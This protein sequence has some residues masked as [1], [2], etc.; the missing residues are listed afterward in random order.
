MSKQAALTRMIERSPMPLSFGDDKVLMAINLF[1]MMAMMYIGGAVVV[2]KVGA[3]IRHRAYDKIWPPHPV[4]LHRIMWACA[5][6]ALTLRCV[7]ETSTLLSWSPDD[8]GLGAVMQ[9][10]KRYIDPISIGFAIT[11]VVVLTLV[12]DSLEQQLRRQPLP[13]NM[14]AKKREL[15]RPSLVVLVSLAMA[16]GVVFTRG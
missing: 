9:T 13:I 15:T 12:N 7:T 8:A 1:L 11:W 2:T 16:F 10:L 14:W 5:G 4:T 6:C 3:I